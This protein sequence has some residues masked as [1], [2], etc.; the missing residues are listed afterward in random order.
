MYV[1]KYP[2]WDGG[3]DEGPEGEDEEGERL[4]EDDRVDDVGREEHA[5]LPK[6]VGQG[7]ALQGGYSVD[8][9]GVDIK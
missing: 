4:V 5:Q 8:V 7:V 2:T 6:D 1:Y 3:A 9:E